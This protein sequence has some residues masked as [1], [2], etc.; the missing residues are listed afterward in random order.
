[1]K[2]YVLLREDLNPTYGAVQAGH[3]VTEFLLRG[4]R[5][6]WNNGTLVYLGMKN[7]EELIAWGERLSIKG[8]EWAGFREPDIGNELTAIACVTDGKVFANLR[9]VKNP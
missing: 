2:L 4:P 3:A 7:E 6:E 5:T 8:L 9:L 1:M